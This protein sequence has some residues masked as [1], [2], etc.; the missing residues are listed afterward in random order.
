ML[1]ALLLLLASFLV[2]CLPLVL[3]RTSMIK[4]LLVASA[5]LL[6]LLLVLESGFFP[7]FSLHFLPFV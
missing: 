2:F 1:V 3:A 5:S 4:L 6:N 7:T